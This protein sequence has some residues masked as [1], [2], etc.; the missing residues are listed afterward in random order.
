DVNL[1]SV[2]GQTA[3]DFLADE[4]IGRAGMPTQKFQA[5]IDAVVIGNRHQI[6]TARLGDAVDRLGI[7]ITVARPEKAQVRR[8]PGVVR[9]H[10]Q[11]GAK[12]R[13]IGHSGFRIMIWMTVEPAPRYAAGSRLRPASTR[14]SVLRGPLKVTLAPRPVTGCQAPPPASRPTAWSTNRSRRYWSS[15]LNEYEPRAMASWA[16]RTAEGTPCILVGSNR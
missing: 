4:E 1:Q 2:I 6:H 12:R 8:V 16:K 14:S 15:T 7:G 11:V 3:L 13:A 10:V 5:A 9:V